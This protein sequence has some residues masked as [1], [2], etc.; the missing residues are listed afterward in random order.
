[1]NETRPGNGHL[2]NRF[3]LII[4]VH[5]LASPMSSKQFLCQRKHTNP[6]WAVVVAQLAERLFPIPEDLGSNPVIG[7]FY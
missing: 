7:N 6:I 5:T 2:Q 1:M 4:F 3:T